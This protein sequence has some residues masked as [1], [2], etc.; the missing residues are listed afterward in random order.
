MDKSNIYLA[1][2]N[3]ASLIAPLRASQTLRTVA[4]ALLSSVTVR[5]RY[6]SVLNIV[7]IS[8]YIVIMYY[9]YST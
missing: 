2:G 5:R 7:E 1:F 6:R 9:K 3:L 8:K 4:N